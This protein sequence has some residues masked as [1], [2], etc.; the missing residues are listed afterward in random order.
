MNVLPDN[1]LMFLFYCI[2]INRFAWHH[3][4]ICSLQA[5]LLSCVDVFSI[6]G[7]SVI[8]QRCKYYLTSSLIQRTCSKI[9]WI[10]SLCVCLW[11]FIEFRSVLLTGSAPD[12][13]ARAG[14]T[15]SRDQLPQ[16][17][18]C[19]VQAQWCSHSAGTDTISWKKQLKTAK[20]NW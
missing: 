15:G 2:P 14:C 16:Q 10:H 7:E 4:F 13:W 8:S 12:S 17:E 1:I 19:S 3:L 18:A 6:Q 20:S 11:V 9:P 5:T